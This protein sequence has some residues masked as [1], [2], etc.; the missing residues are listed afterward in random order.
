[1]KMQLHIHKCTTSGP[2]TIYT[3]FFKQF[4]GYVNSHMSQGSG[5]IAPPSLQNVGQIRNF[6]AAT[7]PYLSKIRIF[8]SATG[9]VWKKQSFFMPQKQLR[10]EVKTFF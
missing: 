7:R 1:M 8:W 6:Q 9:N 3:N 5:A 4:I 2:N 10:F